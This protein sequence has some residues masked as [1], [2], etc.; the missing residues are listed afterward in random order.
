M[1]WGLLHPRGWSEETPPPAMTV[2]AVPSFTATLPD[3]TPVI[4]FVVVPS[5][6]VLNRSEAWKAFAAQW[7]TRYRLAPQE[8]ESVPGSEMFPQGAVETVE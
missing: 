3:G 1:V 4:G 2:V 6:N 8:Q 7:P 5:E